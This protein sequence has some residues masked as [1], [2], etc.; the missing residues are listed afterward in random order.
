MSDVKVNFKYKFPEDYNPTYANGVFGGASPKGE[1]AM[2]FFVE[3]SPIPYSETQQ[4]NEFGQLIPIPALENQEVTVIRYISNGVIMSLDTAKAIH[5]W[6]GN[7]IKN[8]EEEI[9]RG[10]K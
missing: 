2:N 7:H 10:R 4:V 1:I 9:E 5:D 6:L 3:R 8:L